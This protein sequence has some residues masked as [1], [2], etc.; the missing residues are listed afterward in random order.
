M[1]N[2]NL[3]SPGSLLLP[4]AAGCSAAPL[5]GEICAMVMVVD[6]SKSRLKVPAR[7]E[8]EDYELLMARKVIGLGEG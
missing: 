8:S 1:Q 2:F 6:T 3:K 4:L 5:A 7:D